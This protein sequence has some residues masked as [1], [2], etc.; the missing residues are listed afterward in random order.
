[1]KRYTTIKTLLYGAGIYLFC[2]LFFVI[3]CSKNPGSPDPPIEDCP[4]LNCDDCP[5]TDCPEL[6]CDDCL[7]VFIVSEVVD[8]TMEW[9]FV[10]DQSPNKYGSYR[11]DILITTYNTGSSD[12][13]ISVKF[14]ET[15]FGFRLGEE[16]LEIR[17]IG[18][19]QSKASTLGSKIVSIVSV[20]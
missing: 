7:P 5:P 8:I 14:E 10:E 11:S 20:D 15:F 18:E 3:M 9:T 1:M 2:S 6:N 17:L 19:G 16:T 12:P 13:P 4:E